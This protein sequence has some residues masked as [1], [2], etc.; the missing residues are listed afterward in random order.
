MGAKK[1]AG[2]GDDCRRRYLWCVFR[3]DL[4]AS[5]TAIR[6]GVRS[7]QNSIA[8]RRQDSRDQFSHTYN[9]LAAVNAT[10][11]AQARAVPPAT[12]TEPLPCKS[13]HSHHHAAHH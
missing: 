12:A 5:Q 2:I 13:A 1:I 8:E 11:V 7:P 6:R 9:T 4:R 10:V 3:S